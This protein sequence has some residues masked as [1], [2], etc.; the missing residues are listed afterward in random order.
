MNF[1]VFAPNGKDATSSVSGVP[2]GCR[3]YVVGDVHGRL[4]LLYEIEKAIEQ[5]LRTAPSS[6][7]TI[8]LGDYVDRG[9][10]SAGVLE[11]LSSRQFCTD[12][13]ALRG[14]HEQYL[15]DFLSD[16]SLLQ[17]WRKC[18][19]LETLHSYG[20]DIRKAA[21]GEA[22]EAARSA[23]MERLP[24]KHF[25]FLSATLFS[26]VLGEYFFCH[27]GVR[28]GVPLE[29]Q[30]PNDL[31]TIRDDFLQFSG[32]FGRIVVHGHSPIL[33]PDVKLNRINI[34][35]CAHASGVLTALV[36]EADSR[37]FLST[38]HAKPPFRMPAD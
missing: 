11:K 18:G 27:A 20:L 24:T 4:D 3:L 6:V 9:F 14:N 37:R 29:R 35:T 32:S 13:V 17:W 12:F 26:F 38:G 34:D 21:R 28:P 15:L 7:L 31:L 23:L 30:S 25:D 33:K 8:F 16:A 5:D 19:G 2:I 22:C 36:L 1:W 10:Q